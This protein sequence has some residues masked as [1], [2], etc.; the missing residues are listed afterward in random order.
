MHV[1]VYI[2]WSLLCILRR[3]FRRFHQRLH[4]ETNRSYR[5]RFLRTLLMAQR[6][7]V[8]SRVHS[9]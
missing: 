5:H 6:H 4:H 3:E 7:G 9:G 8:R 1:P 2:L